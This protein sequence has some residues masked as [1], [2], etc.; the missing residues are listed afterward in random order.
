MFKRK[1]GSPAKAGGGCIRKSRFRSPLYSTT[2]LNFN[3][4]LVF[5]ST[6]SFMFFHRVKK[7]FTSTYKQKKRT[8]LQTDAYIEIQIFN[9]RRL[10]PNPC[11]YGLGFSGY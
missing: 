11:P 3:R 5:S 4:S 10:E 9:S 6:L 2:V 8:G 1:L 7:L